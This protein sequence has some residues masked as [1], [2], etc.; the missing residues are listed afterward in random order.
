V[1]GAPETERCVDVLDPVPTTELRG[2]VGAPVAPSS[3]VAGVP[4]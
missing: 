3:P 4:A 1:T 2:V